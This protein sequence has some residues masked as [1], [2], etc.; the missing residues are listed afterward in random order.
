MG[1][2]L[3]PCQDCASPNRVCM[4]KPDAGTVLI[5]TVIKKNRYAKTDFHP[6]CNLFMHYI[7]IKKRQLLGEFIEK[8]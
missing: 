8:I 3:K 5:F 4:E 7:T 6:Q 1:I 2:T